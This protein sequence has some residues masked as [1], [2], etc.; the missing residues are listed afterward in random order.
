MKVK[1]KYLEKRYGNYY[2]RYRVPKDLQNIFGRKEIR[3]SLEEMSLKNAAQLCSVYAKYI[4]KLCILVR[5]QNLDSREAQQLLNNFFAESNADFYAQAKLFDIDT[6]AYA[7]GKCRE[8][9]SEYI[10]SD[11][12]VYMLDPEGFDNLPPEITSVEKK[13]KYFVDDMVNAVLNKAKITLEKYSLDYYQMRHVTAEY[14]F[15][16]LKKL[17]SQFTERG[18]YTDSLIENASN[19]SS[20][21]PSIVHVSQETTQQTKK[22]TIEQAVERYIKEKCSLKQ[23]GVSTRASMEAAVNLVAEYCSPETDI[24]EIT[25]DELIELRKLL[26]KIPKHRNKKKEYV[27]MHV[28]DFVRLDIEDTIEL[29]TQ[30]NLMKYIITFFTWCN[31]PQAKLID[32]NIA[33]GLQIKADPNVRPDQA[34]DNFTIDELCLIL[35]KL[36]YLPTSNLNWAWQ[37]WVPIIAM[38]TGNRL[39]EVCQ[40]YIS[41]IVKKDGIAI[42]DINRFSKHND[43]RLKTRAAIRLIPIHSNLLKLN[44]LG[45]VAEVKA[46]GAERLFPALTYDEG[47]GYK[48]K[49]V[50]WFGNFKKTN[51]STDRKKTFHSLRGNFISQLNAAN[52]N[53]VYKMYLSGHAQDN[54]T[55]AIY[56]SPTVAQLKE[57]VELLDYGIETFP[58]LRKEPL[59]DE[60]IAEQVKQLPV[61]E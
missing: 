28:R 45:F 3:R 48:R 10:C 59:S 24:K 61:K 12:P 58:L 16:L 50:R 7:A 41:D 21:Q 23:W 13:K 47:Q 38:H 35:N 34:R 53:Q 33:E 46:T 42:F 6:R 18:F 49:V 39:N 11:P 43:K 30:K 52:A 27:G 37:Y 57:T 2:F 5:E 51:I 14:C 4:H 29:N 54:I 9:A 40:L 25:R 44:F 1:V 17:E 26:S 19:A 55:N 22:V 32:V 56:T 60:I 20:S 36:A 8:L 31:S 15:E